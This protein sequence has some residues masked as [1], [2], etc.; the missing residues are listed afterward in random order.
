MQYALVSSAAFVLSLIFVALVLIVSHRL[1][2]YDGHDERKIHTGSV[3]RLGGIGFA[4]AFIL[5]AV[6][7]TAM[8]L[9]EGMTGRIGLRFIPILIAMPLILVFGVVDDFRPLRPRYKLLVQIIAAVLVVSTDFTFQRVS[10]SGIGLNLEFGALR[11]AVTVLWIV[12]VTNALNLIDG[13]DGLAGGV[14][15][16]AILSYAAIFGAAGNGGAVL[17]CLALAGAILGFLA[18]NLPLPKARIFMGDGGSQFLGFM[19]AV[20]PL[21]T[22]GAG[23]ASIALPFA[24]A[25]LLIPIFDTFSAIWRRTRDGRRI[26]CPDRA[27]MHHKLMNLGLRARGV[28]G[29]SYAL[30]ISLGV[31]VFLALR[32]RSGFVSFALLSAA[33]AIAMAYFIAIHYLNRRANGK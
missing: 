8:D 3:P 21:F 9:S 14:S 11:Y 25:I 4:G 1:A 26:D 13:V 32:R 2:W 30:Q 31:L 24:A 5:V 7:L 6:A 15:L 18:F 27:H 22:D 10:F 16:F 23:N 19:L 12:G 28:I 20:L 33:Y 17:L 29:I